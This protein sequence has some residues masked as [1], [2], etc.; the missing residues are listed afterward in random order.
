MPSISTRDEWIF[1]QASSS[2]EDLDN[3]FVS[4]HLDDAI[5]LCH[6]LNGEM[7]AKSAARLITTIARREVIDDP[8]ARTMTVFRI[9]RLLAASLIHF[10]QEHE[11]ILGLL[12]AIQDLPCD[13]RIHWWKLPTFTSRWS[14]CYS[15]HRDMGNQKNVAFFKNAGY[16]EATMYLR[17]ISGIEEEWAYGVINLV[18][19]EM[20]EFEFEIHQV[21]EWLKVA[22]SKLVETLQPAKLKVFDRA[23]RGRSN[24]TYMIEVTMYEHWEHWKKRFL[25][26][27]HDEDFLS[28][29]SRQVAKECHEIMK[30]L[31][32]EQPDPPTEE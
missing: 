21:C 8:D 30:G 18:C 11:M 4:C 3:I 10:D 13:G 31:V 19:L 1:S 16:L 24:K 25:Q 17:G 7:N 9:M 22:G 32:V 2:L 5:T 15:E 28:T 23:V 20:E 26:V 27:S 6:Y 12:L 29:E 14:N